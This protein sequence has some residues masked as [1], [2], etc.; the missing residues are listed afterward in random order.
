MASLLQRTTPASDA[1]FEESTD[2]DLAERQPLPS[3]TKE[4]STVG[5]CEDGGLPAQQL[6]QISEEHAIIQAFIVVKSRSYSK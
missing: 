3:T 2:P 5:E 4:G 6:T 1:S